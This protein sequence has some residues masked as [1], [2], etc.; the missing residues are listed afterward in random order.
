MPKEIELKVLDVNKEQLI[1]RLKALK[2]RKLPVQNFRRI[3][4]FIKDDKKESVWLRLRTD[5]KKV[6]L[7]LKEQ[8]GSG[9]TQT[10]E[11]ETEVKDFKTT[12]KILCKS[13]KRFVY[14]ET[15]RIPYL[16][17]GAEITI[18][19]WPDIPW[20]MEIEGKSKDH[21]MQLY[22]EL[23]VSGRPVGNINADVAYKMY[24][25]NFEEIAKKN[26]KKLLALIN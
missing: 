20:F 13:F 8:F 11:Y 23:N 1:K 25:L 4:F 15:T 12:A 10:N 16:Y 24:G 7:T 21:V 22:K 6:T 5:G 26:N 14:E 2:A 18:D 9:L 3:I 19:K 17:K